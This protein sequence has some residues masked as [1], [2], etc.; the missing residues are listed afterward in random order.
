MKRPTHGPSLSLSVSKAGTLASLMLALGCVNLD[1]PDS[2]RIC[3]SSPEGC[4]DNPRPKQAD[5]AVADGQ[6]DSS[7]GR[8]D[9]AVPA[10][11]E[12]TASDARVVADRGAERIMLADAAADMDTGMADQSQRSEVED[13]DS[14]AGPDLLADLS[15]SSDLLALYDAPEPDLPPPDAVAG[16]D[17]G[18]DR[19]VSGD[20]AYDT[21]PEVSSS[22]VAQII[23]NGYQAGSAPACSA[24]NDGNGGSLASPCMQMLDCLLPPST[25]A[26]YLFCLN[27]IHASSLV[28]DCVSALTKAGCPNGY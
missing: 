20:S 3:A 17:L 19:S 22:C 27:S 6:V 25:S 11:G 28:G 12:K 23:A 14:G 9:A 24:C 13:A 5:A 4:S 18:S 16:L 10:D 7:S 21:A 2:V 15:V 8:A 1:K 26:S